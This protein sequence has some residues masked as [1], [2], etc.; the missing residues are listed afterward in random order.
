MFS[1]KVSKS[2][3]LSLLIL[4]ALASAIRL[5]VPG[6]LLKWGLESY[7]GELCHG[8]VT[9]RELRGGFFSGITIKD[10]RL[11]LKAKA[12]PVLSID[13]I[14]TD[15][16]VV[17]KIPSTK[18]CVIM[19]P[20]IYL[21]ECVACLDQFSLPMENRLL[22][23]PG[24]D[25]WRGANFSIFGCQIFQSYNRQDNVLL[26]DIV[27]SVR[28]IKNQMLEVYLGTPKTS[29]SSSK[30][31]VYGSV[32]TAR[33]SSNLDIDLNLSRLEGLNLFLRSVHVLDGSAHVQA[34]L[35]GSLLETFG[36]Q[37][38]NV[39]LLFSRDRRVL[40][41][42]SGKLSSN[43]QFV[44]LKDCKGDGEGLHF[45]IQGDAKS[46][47]FTDG[48]IDIHHAL[49]Q[50][51]LFA[52]SLSA[53]P[54]AL[55]LETSITIFYRNAQNITHL[56]W[57]KELL[58]SL[59]LL[60]GKMRVNDEVEVE[61]TGKYSPGE[62][63]LLDYRILSLDFGKIRKSWFGDKFGSL[64]GD[65][66]I[67]GEGRALCE[68]KEVTLSGDLDCNESK[69]AYRCVWGN[70]Q[71]QIKEL[72]VDE[73]TTLSGILDLVHREKSALNLRFQDESITR[74]VHAM[75]FEKPPSLTGKFTGQVDILG[76]LLD[77]RIQGTL[78]I[79]HG[80]IKG[81]PF[82]QGQIQL[83]GKFPRIQLDRSVIFLQKNMPVMLSGFVD[84]S[85]KDMFKTVTSE[86]KSTA[87]SGRVS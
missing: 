59:S 50:S 32:H 82:S 79:R 65:M 67:L 61:F 5:R 9:I 60:E 8:R 83:A 74:S 23:L 14:T 41:H 53:E 64:F 42:L 40:S 16:R 10:T 47:V 75:G 15:F 28:P 4:L 81:I 73:A 6:H 36:V 43:S 84:L 7:L 71:L 17:G 51:R 21:E 54:I 1:S 12:E 35:R 55:D 86:S 26:Q 46:L 34:T 72:H 70:R 62:P 11:Y 39:R 80:T 19:R 52:Q 76:D 56:Q 49:I 69:M 58:D 25:F 20:R 63:I 33:G 2:C 48:R 45:E 87:D 27:G 31:T 29:P 24:G 68:W 30:L 85:A 57:G 66:K 13:E 3:I 77:P 78:D 37:F 18:N 22:F 44:T 38:Q